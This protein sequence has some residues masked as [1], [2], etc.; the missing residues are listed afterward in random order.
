[1][2]LTLDSSADVT[3]AA[4]AV[5]EQAELHEIGS[6]T[7]ADECLP[8]CPVCALNAEYCQVKTG[9]I[10]TASAL[11]AQA[12]H[13]I[14]LTGSSADVDAGTVTYTTADGGT[15]VSSQTDGGQSYV[16]TLRTAPKR[17]M[18]KVPRLMHLF[19]P[20]RMSCISP[21][22]KLRILELSCILQMGQITAAKAIIVPL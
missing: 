18:G 8:D 15:V 11:Y 19:I 9:Q 4:T 14:D 21:I 3:Q 7:C 2:N 16:Y 10:Y 1:M 12:E 22:T 6:C 13:R 5:Y 20:M 17:P